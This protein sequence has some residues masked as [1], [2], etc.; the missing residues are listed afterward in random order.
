M[1]FDYIPLGEQG[2]IWI[3]G[4]STTHVDFGPIQRLACR[5]VTGLKNTYPSVF[6]NVEYACVLE[7]MGCYNEQTGEPG[8]LSFLTPGDILYVPE[9]DLDVNSLL[10]QSGANNNLYKIESDGVTSTLL[11]EGY[12][13]IG[14]ILP[15]GWE[16]K[17]IPYILQLQEALAETN[18]K[19][20]SSNVKL[21]SEVAL[22]EGIR[23]AVVDVKNSPTDA[24][25]EPIY[26]GDRADKRK[27]SEAKIADLLAQGYRIYSTLGISEDLARVLFVKYPEP[28]DAIVQD[29]SEG[30][31]WTV[32]SADLSECIR[33]AVDSA[34]FDAWYMDIINNGMM[35]NDP[36]PDGVNYECNIRLSTNFDPY[37]SDGL[38]LYIGSMEDGMDVHPSSWES[39][40][41][42]GISAELAP[43]VTSTVVTIKRPI[44]FT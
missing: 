38:A 43:G 8:E 33:F 44:L 28:N 9:F 16:G 7:Y 30:P 23:G 10:P 6:A 42:F 17:S 11:I 26:V 35:M 3:D 24:L 27:K 39:L 14:E 32:T 36:A 19:L 41:N 40:A 18:A 34:V 22:T 20:D 2:W 5:R 21:D 4:R 12:V 31:Q 29:D 37:S 13:R 25:L 15:G 1:E